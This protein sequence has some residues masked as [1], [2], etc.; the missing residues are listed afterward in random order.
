MNNNFGLLLIFDTNYLYK[1]EYNNENIPKYIKIII[2]NKSINKIYQHN[3]IQKSEWWEKFKIFFNY[4]FDNCY[5]LLLN[6]CNNK[7]KD[8]EK[9]INILNNNS[10]NL[11]INHNIIDGFK[12]NFILNSK[13]IKIKTHKI[14]CCMSPQYKYYNNGNIKYK[15]KYNKNSVEYYNNNNN[16]KYEGK[17]ENNEYNGYGI[18]YFNNDLNTINLKGIF[19]DGLLHG[20][21]IEYT[22]INTV[23]YNGNFKEGKYNGKGILYN[24]NKILYEGNFKNN[25]YENSGTLYDTKG[26]ILY[27]G[28]FKN[29]KYENSGTLYDTKGNILY[30]GNFKNCMYYGKGILYNDGRI[31]YNGLF[32]D[33]KYDDTGILYKDNNIIYNGMFK[34]GKKHGHGINGKN[35][36]CYYEED[37]FIRIIKDE[38]LCNIC[39]DNPSEIAFIPCGHKC[40]CSDC[41]KGYNNDIC[42]ICRKELVIGYKIYD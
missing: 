4:N 22:V 35:E 30:E 41:Y 3:I 28:N 24:N 6:V 9:K 39:L 8:F 37:I 19:K 14:K 26:N 10:I 42:I 12:L 13:S 18:Y 27:E 7:L 17:I 15:Y 34:D 23:R 5:N 32:K 36:Y 1:L 21:A 16:K 2:Q 33:G 40:I 29:N 25:K 38:N 20:E 31:L 11:Y